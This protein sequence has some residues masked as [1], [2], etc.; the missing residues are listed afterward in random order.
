MKLELTKSELQ[1][2]KRALDVYLAQQDFEVARTHKREYRHDLVL[3]H[4]VLEALRQ[5]IAL[6]LEP[7]PSEAPAVVP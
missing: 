1:G 5:R 2:L 7:T 4:E 6:V 3:D